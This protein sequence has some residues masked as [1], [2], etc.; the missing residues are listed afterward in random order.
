VDTLPH[1]QELR[2]AKY[3]SYA[4]VEKP[5]DEFDD[6]WVDPVNWTLLFGKALRWE[7]VVEDRYRQLK[8]EQLLKA[9]RDAKRKEVDEYIWKEGSR[10]IRGGESGQRNNDAPY[11]A[12]FA[13]LVDNST[14]ATGIEEQTASAGRPSFKR[15]KNLARE[16]FRS[17][18]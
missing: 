16:A 5:A 9:D 6:E 3:Y 15:G 1:L 17:Q 11:N 8:T 13:T 10:I 4:P 14:A 18:K 2:L 7:G 12:S